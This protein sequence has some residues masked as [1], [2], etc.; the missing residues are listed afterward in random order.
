MRDLIQILEGFSNGSPQNAIN[1]IEQGYLHGLPLSPSCYAVVGAGLAEMDPEDATIRLWGLRPA[2]VAH[3]DA[4]VHPN[5][6]VIS[7]I[8][9]E[10]YKRSGYELVF[11][12][13]LA[14]LKTHM[15]IQ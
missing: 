8:P 12:C 5:E 14:D 9:V 11:T 3:A 4:V 13:S 2:L 7:D 10:I 15:G 1:K 6:H